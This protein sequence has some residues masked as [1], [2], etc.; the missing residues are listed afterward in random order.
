MK[1]VLLFISMNRHH[2]I[3]PFESPYHHSVNI[4]SDLFLVV[5]RHNYH[6][7]LHKS[8]EVSPFRVEAGKKWVG[9]L[10]SL[11]PSFVG[12]IQSTPVVL[13]AFYLRSIEKEIDS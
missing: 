10:Y 9:L 6:I 13:R 5:L 7:T 2:F 8:H 3:K 12:W 4:G 11:L 1:C